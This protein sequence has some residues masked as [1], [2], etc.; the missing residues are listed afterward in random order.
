MRRLRWVTVSP[1]TGP[2]DRPWADDLDEDAVGRSARGVCERYSEALRQAD[3]SS[4]YSELQLLCRVDDQCRDV[5]VTVYSDGMGESEVAV[6]LMPL[7]VAKLPAAVRARL[8][9]EVVH[10]A[11][12]R[13]GRERGWDPAAL[14]SAYEHTVAAGLRYRWQ[15]PPKASPD[16]RHSAQGTFWLGDDGNGLA[17][18]KLRRRADGVIVAVSEPAP[19]YNTSSSFTRSAQTLRWVSNER[20]EMIASAALPIG[21]AR[22]MLVADARDA[23]TVAIGDGD[24][25]RSPANRCGAD[26]VDEAAV[27]QAT[28]RVSVIADNETGSRIDV[29]GGSI[30]AGVPDAYWTTLHHYLEQLTSPAWQQWWSS[31]P[32]RVL[33]IWYDTVVTT[34]TVSVRRFTEGLRV[35]IRR[36]ASTF[37]TAPAHPAVL[38]RQDIDAMLSAVRR[39]TGLPLPP[40]LKPPP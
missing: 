13:L 36:P 27:L 31:A 32:E 2:R 18:V 6:A 22:T 11:A 3:L 24:A 5:L 28:P 25:D 4:R 14:Q 38:A 1:Q 23:I 30:D 21:T 26:D 17:V 9:L 10:G 8:V 7:G 16:R 40:P 39:R 29:V 34:S 33:E 37:S 19:A 35:K 20:V 12:L 15:S